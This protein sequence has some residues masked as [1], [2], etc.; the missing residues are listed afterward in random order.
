MNTDLSVGNLFKIVNNSDEVSTWQN[1]LDSIRTEL[2][3]NEDK[4]KRMVEQLIA[5]LNAY[6]SLSGEISDT[7]HFKAYNVREK[8]EEVAYDAIL[9]EKTANDKT[10]QFI[11]P[12]KTNEVKHNID[13][14]KVELIEK[15]LSFVPKS[16]IEK[17]D[18]AHDKRK[19]RLL[20]E[21][22]GENTVFICDLES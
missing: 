10:K 17:L 15:L 8:K 11:Y 1:P 19:E 4:Q 21:C 7:P 13:E 9:V 16:D 2:P 12:P 6:F 5:E 14:M 18:A 3:S 22:T 20:A